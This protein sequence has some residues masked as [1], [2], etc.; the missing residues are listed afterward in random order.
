MSTEGEEIVVIGKRR[1]DGSAS[2]GSSAYLDFT[3]PRGYSSI[4]TIT[5][6]ADHASNDGFI[7]IPTANGPARIKI[8]TTGMSDKLVPSPSC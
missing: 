5:N 4:I 8:D 7:V 1:E 6:F 2:G 3:F